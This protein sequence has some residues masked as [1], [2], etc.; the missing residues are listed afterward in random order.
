VRYGDGIA[1]E[2]LESLPLKET[3]WVVSTLPDMASN[4][5]LLRGLQELHFTGEVAVVARDE[6]DGVALK[7]MGTPT[8]LYPMRDA[9]NYAVEFLVAIIHPKEHAT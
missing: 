7:Q 4:R 1:S 8:V 3:R 2:F 6:L 9:V 5:D